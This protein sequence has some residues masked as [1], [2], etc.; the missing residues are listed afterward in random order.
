MNLLFQHLY[1]FFIKDKNTGTTIF[2]MIYRITP[3]NTKS[4]LVIN[5]TSFRIGELERLK[6]STLDPYTA[7][8][9]VYLQHR[10]EQ[11]ER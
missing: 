1:R 10:Q 4:Y 11:V 5:E 9:N 6:E 8:R 2:R 3:L 7:Y